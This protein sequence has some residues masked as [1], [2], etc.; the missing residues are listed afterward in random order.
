MP[1]SFRF[2][3]NERQLTVLRR[4]AEG[5]EPVTSAEPHLALTVYALRDRGL[6]EAKRRAGRWAATITR[7]RRRNSQ[8][9]DPGPT[10][11]RP[12]MAYSH[13]PGGPPSVQVSRVI[14]RHKRPGMPG[15]AP[16]GCECCIR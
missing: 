6:V 9:A 7:Q 16:R 13:H 12:P 15:H 2:V 4:I 10:H 14:S 1:R 3:L 5:V 8:P 11:L